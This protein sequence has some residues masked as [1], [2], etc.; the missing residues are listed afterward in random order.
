MNCPAC[1]D[2]IGRTGVCSCGEAPPDH[3]PIRPTQPISV[4]SEMVGSGDLRVMATNIEAL[5]KI[6]ADAVAQLGRMIEA[7][8]QRIGEGEASVGRLSV[9][10]SAIELQ[11]DEIRKAIYALEGK[12]S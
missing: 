9:R 5:A 10:L 1:G 8:S 2:P 11:L 3:G 6:T 7:T 12:A 4:Y